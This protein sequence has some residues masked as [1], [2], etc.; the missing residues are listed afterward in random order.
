M[1]SLR[2]KIITMHAEHAIAKCVEDAE[3]A[4]NTEKII[5]CTT[6]CLWTRYYMCDLA[7]KLNNMHGVYGHVNIKKSSLA[8]SINTESYN[9]NKIRQ[10]EALNRP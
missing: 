9:L 3:L 7:N 8:F 2:K 5:Q 4:G 10:S 1:A 6:S